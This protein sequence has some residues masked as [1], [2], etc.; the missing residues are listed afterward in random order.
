LTEFRRNVLKGTQI[1]FSG[2]FPTNADPE[3]TDIWRT[4]KSFGAKCSTNL[5]NKTTHL[6]AANVGTEKVKLA[7]E[8]NVWIVKPDWLY[9]CA[10]RWARIEGD[11]FRFPVS[12]SFPAKLEEDDERILPQSEPE[13]SPKRLKVEEPV[14]NDQKQE[15]PIALTDVDFDAEFAAFL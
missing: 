10:W 3:T 5:S 7:R 4:A 6:I 9:D 13:K 1:V 12:L 11:E 15:Q 2:M 14:V 8:K